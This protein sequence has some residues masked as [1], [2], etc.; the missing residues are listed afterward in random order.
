MLF[1]I[2]FL[3]SAPAYIRFILLSRQKPR[4]F[5]P[6]KQSLRTKTITKTKT[7]SGFPTIEYNNKKLFFSGAR[8]LLTKYVMAL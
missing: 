1:C 8:Y 7:F 4:F 3:T 5:E 2:L 6:K